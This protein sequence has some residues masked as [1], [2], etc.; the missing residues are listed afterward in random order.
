MPE[1]LPIED[2]LRASCQFLGGLTVGPELNGERERILTQLIPAALKESERLNAT[3]RQSNSN[4]TVAALTRAR[5][6]LADDEVGEPGWFGDRDE[7]VDEIEALLASNSLDSRVVFALSRASEVLSGAV[8][9]DNPVWAESRE[10]TELIDDL[11]E[12]MGEA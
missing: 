4:K 8:T 12:A 5:D 3:G 7:F 6:L 2:A 11:M 10:V 9:E 1:I